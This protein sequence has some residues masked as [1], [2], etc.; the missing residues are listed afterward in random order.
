MPDLLFLSSLTGL[1]PYLRVNP[2]NKL[3]GYCL[4]SLTG[5]GAYRRVNSFQ[6]ESVQAEFCFFDTR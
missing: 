6:A 2:G 5:L 1:G 4:S 3:P